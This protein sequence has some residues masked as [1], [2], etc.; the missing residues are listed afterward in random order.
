MNTW[1]PSLPGK[2]RR[3]TKTELGASPIPPGPSAP[4]EAS[5]A[6]SS[7]AGRR[8]CSSPIRS[9]ASVP[10]SSATSGCGSWNRSIRLRPSS[11]LRRAPNSASAA[12]LTRRIRSFASVAMTGS[13][14]LFT[15]SVIKVRS[16]MRSIAPA[17]SWAMSVS[18]R[19][20]SRENALT[21][22]SSTLTMKRTRSPSENR[23]GTASSER[24]GS[25]S[26]VRR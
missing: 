14:T 22:G 18:C 6:A 23:M 1:P 17:T 11:A 9:P 2:S 7:Q 19:T 26:G 15:H 20:C 8:T 3:V 13:A 5:A 25:P 10:C 12:G 24:I 16:L 4:W 21:R